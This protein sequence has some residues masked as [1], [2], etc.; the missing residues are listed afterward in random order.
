MPSGTA[1]VVVITGAGGMGAAVAHRIG[2]GSTILLADFDEAALERERATLAAAGHDVATRVTDVSSPAS[3]DDL[4]ADAASRGAVTTLVHTAGVSPVQAPVEAIMRVDLYG[5]ALMLDAFAEVISPGG[6]AVCISSMAGTMASIDQ[7][8]EAKLANTPT[9]ELLALPELS[10]GAIPDSGIAYTIAKRGNQVRVRAASL[11][12]GRRG[13]RV[14]SISPGV[15]STPMGAAELAGP[16]GEFMRALVDAS[17]TGRLGTP[18]DIAN[19][20][21]FLTSREAS[22]VTGTDLLVDGGV[23]ASLI[24]PRA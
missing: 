19:A 5:T 7:A 23:I 9:D 3:V 20:V 11:A 21:A 2:A 24:V 15:I 16:S 8:F 10:A 12:W 4:A 22:F 14:N 6:S 18:D 13:A 17:G 1:S